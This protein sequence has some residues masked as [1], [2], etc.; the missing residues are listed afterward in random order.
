M[1]KLEQ[2]HYLKQTAI[3]VIILLTPV[4]GVVVSDLKNFIKQKFA[5]GVTKPN[6]ILHAIREA[7]MSEPIKSKITSYLQHLR[8]EK[9]GQ[10]M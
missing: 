7:K 5:D 10:T 1:L 8:Y 9:Y 6:A 3:T 4:E 2:C